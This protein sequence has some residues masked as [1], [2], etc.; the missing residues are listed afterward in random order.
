MNL[1]LSSFLPSMM[2]VIYMIFSFFY[3]L[4]IVE[5]V[6]HF[7]HLQPPFLFAG[8]FYGGY[9]K[10]PGGISELVANFL[11]QSYFNNILGSIV[12]LMTALIIWALVISLLN[13]IYKSKLNRIWAFIPFTLLIALSNDFNF[14]FS[15]VVSVLIVVLLLNVLNKTGKTISGFIITYILST[16]SVYYISGS[17]FFLMYTVSAVLFIPNRTW[18]IK[19]ILI[20]ILFIFSVFVPKLA[21]Q[22]IF[23]LSP[24]YEYLY[25]FPWKP[26]FLEYKPELVF[27]TFL[28]SFP[29][30]FLS[31]IIFK[32]VF[33]RQKL[34]GTIWKLSK[35]T[36]DL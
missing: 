10:H 26:Y 15:I 4:L 31:V 14:P 19:S 27:Y 22:H 25:F 30:I 9:N 34:Q 12:F 24:N 11:L 16:I 13:Q 6:L 36:S 29:T 35:R 23:A 21:Y 5:P 18:T 8:D 2:P 3:I 7:H 1:K 33:K 17:G 20:A 28:L 32:V